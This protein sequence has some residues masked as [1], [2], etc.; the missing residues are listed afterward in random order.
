VQAVGGA[1]ILG[2]VA[3]TIGTRRVSAAVEP[4]VTPAT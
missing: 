3:M 1:L 2:G 4:E